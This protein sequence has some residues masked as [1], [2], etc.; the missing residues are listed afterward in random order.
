MNIYVKINKTF[1]DEKSLKAFATIF[2]EKQLTITGVRVLESKNGLCVMMPSRKDSK[3]EYR[4]VCF[5]ITAELRN[6]INE[7][8]LKA[9]DEHE[10]DE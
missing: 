10:E 7:A 6:K 8:V 2:V 9:Y 5:P 4:D 3:G 1:E